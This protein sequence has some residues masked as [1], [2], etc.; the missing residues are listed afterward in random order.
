M[1]DMQNRKIII[2]RNWWEQLTFYGTLYSIPGSS[3]GLN[4]TER[5]NQT[6]LVQGLIAKMK[7]KDV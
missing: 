3:K 6:Q 4:R 1:K 7:H 5:L 2:K